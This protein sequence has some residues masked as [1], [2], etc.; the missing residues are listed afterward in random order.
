MAV[1]ATA[2][3]GI[4][5]GLMWSDLGEWLGCFSSLMALFYGGLA[6]IFIR[7]GAENV[8][9]AFFSLGLALLFLTIAIPAQIGDRALTTITWAAKGTILIWL[10]LRLRM[11]L[12][13]IASY[14]VFAA[15]S[16]RLLFFDTTL[17]LHDFTPVL[18]ERF[19]AFIVSIAA[20]YLAGYLLWRGRDS[21]WAREQTAWSVYPIFFAV[22]NFFTL[23]LLSTEVWD[24][25]TKQL[26][27][28]TDWTARDGLRS[29]R[30]LSLTGL[31][32]GYAVILLV[33][34]ITRRWRMVRLAALGLLVIPIVK[35]FVYDVFALEQVYRIIAFIGLGIL[36][37]VSAYL[38]QRHRKTIMG[39]LTKE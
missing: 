8:T 23:V 32:A 14:I 1:N 20:I 15:M 13:R 22:A 4:S 25:F 24:F 38:Y 30:N 21:L 39:F 6:Y 36:L 16:I 9:L 17:S 35:V 27:T 18:N 34:G 31:W 29:A 26:S 19:L 11:S 33:V 37:L 7:K 3:F 10:S 5:F 28:T 12:L 2:Y